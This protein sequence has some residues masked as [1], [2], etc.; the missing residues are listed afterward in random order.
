MN[1]GCLV[2]CIFTLLAF[3]FCM[4]GR[5]NMGLIYNLSRR[6]LESV[7]YHGRRDY[8]VAVSLL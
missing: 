8:T 2:T 3:D 6:G 1:S 7:S 5:A 4:L